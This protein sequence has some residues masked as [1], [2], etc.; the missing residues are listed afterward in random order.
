V[1]RFFRDGVNHAEVGVVQDIGYDIRDF[2]LLELH[3]AVR[4]ESQDIAGFGGCGFL[5]SECPVIVEIDYRDVLGTDREWRH[6]FYTGEPAEGWP[7]YPWTVEIPAGT[8]RTFDSG[9]LMVELADTPPAV[10]Q[11]VI[12]YASGH[13]F[14]AM[15]TELELMAQE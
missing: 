5:S 1:V 11:R 14:T 13:S 3:M 2:S 10:I 8:W 6:G 15:V 7:L 9:N 12:V 4:I